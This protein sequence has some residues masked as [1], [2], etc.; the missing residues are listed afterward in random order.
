MLRLDRTEDADTL[1]TTAMGTWPDNAAIAGAWA[2]LAVR[3]NDWAEAVRRWET[4]R[5]LLPH[6][7]EGYVFGSQALARVGRDADAERLLDEGRV[8]NPGNL[9]LATSWAELAA[10]RQEWPTAADRWC[11]VRQAFPHEM[12]VQLETARGLAECGR[13]AETDAV[14]DEKPCPD[15]RR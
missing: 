15:V 8:N 11:A 4:V 10:R 14:L 3:R 2:D 7:P 9:G 5:A 1:L 12:R 6:A 13:V